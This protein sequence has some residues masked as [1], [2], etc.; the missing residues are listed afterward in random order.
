MQGRC[1]LVDFYLQKV[2]RSRIWRFPGISSR[3][4]D[5]L[6]TCY[7]SIR[8]WYKDLKLV[9]LFS[10]FRSFCCPEL[11]CLEFGNDKSHICSFEY[12]SNRICSTS[13][14]SSIQCAQHPYFPYTYMA[15][16]ANLTLILHPEDSICIPVKA[17][18]QLQM[19]PWLCPKNVFLD[20]FCKS[21]SNLAP[22]LPFPPLSCTC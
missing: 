6:V 7:E 11:L 15:L 21:F 4:C 3:F 8:R 1:P 17:F 12:C 22:R 9:A 18:Q 5:S 20:G 13:R 14:L 16:S 2:C 10:A 19:S